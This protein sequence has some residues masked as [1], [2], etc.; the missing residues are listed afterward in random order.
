M[1]DLS[2]LFDPDRV[3]VVGA[4]DREGS[5]GRALLE[6]LASFD[7]EVIPVN[8]NRET[9]LGAECYPEIGAVPD[10][11]S[12]DLAVVAVPAAAAV[13]V[14]RE[15]G[16]AGIGTVVVVT[17]GF[18]E[19][20]ER[21]ERRER[22]LIEVAEEYDLDLLGPNCVGVISTPAGLN[23]TFA[24]GTPPEG[25]ISLVSQSG[26]FIAAVLGWAAQHGV[27]F[28]HVVSL[29]NEAVLD[30]VDFLAEW[31]ADPETDVVL[32]YLEDI[33]EGRAFIETAREV[34]S[35]TPVVVIK[36]GRT[37]AGAE[38]AASHTGSMAGADQAYRAGFH[39]AGVLRAMD[40]EEVF[41]FGQVLEGGPLLDR[42]DIAVVTNGGGPGVLAAD[43]V[44][45]S[46]LRM[47]EFD[48]EVRATLADL[49]PDEADVRNP[50]DVIGDA[51][52]DRFGRALDAVLGAG[53]VGGAV[54]ICVPTAV[55]EFEALADV[56]GELQER[57]GKPVV[58]CLMGGAEA[59]RAAERL[60]SYGIPNYFD[61]ARAVTSL[62][63]LADYREVTER[64]YEPPAAF[65]VDRERAREV[66]AGAVERGVDRLGV[67]AMDI[68]D[69]YGIPTPAG[70]LAESGSAARELAEGI[71]GPVV[72]KLVSP[73][74]VHKSDV[75]GVEVGVPV[76]EVPD[77]YRRI[78]ERA[79]EH[80][81]DATLLGV[82]VEALVDPEESTETIVGVNRDEQF[83][84]LL[85]FGLGGIFVQ[86][87]EDTSF[88]VAP[89]S[90]H[91][92]REMTD[93]IKAAPMLRGARGR[94]PADLDAV[95]ETI[96][97]VSQ[98]VTDF[99]AITELDV[100]PL[101][102]A[103]D[104]VYAVDLRLTVDREA[105]AAAE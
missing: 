14:V 83:G 80:D 31:G 6:N 8:P 71:G 40:V 11:A 30:E 2:A 24:R 58:T 95:V 46:R 52:V 94:T 93:E 20:G 90:E 25:S 59:D 37:A 43:S 81:P 66:L 16:T 33:D 102:A 87:F 32:A 75:G 15:V 45:D 64:S 100:N 47:A 55:F 103:P 7:G 82:R 69:A 42:D 35:H 62:E 5:V 99:P 85:M 18:S 54:V 63:A 29:G 13:D 89:V 27:G 57:H 50:L 48:E 84:H 97:R 23:A 34:T 19:A 39:E 10:V 12:V 104:G 51:D 68:L 92:A 1:S 98:L 36:S 86:V 3:A 4:T 38:A 70:G 105:L 91:E 76:E 78:R 73:D 67:E 21:G 96:Q 9:V 77:T 101:V 74:I 26:A 28:R 53:T 88:R 44:G 79:T 60:E 22:E 61:P 65:D 56:V 17:A 49:L 41:D 72:M